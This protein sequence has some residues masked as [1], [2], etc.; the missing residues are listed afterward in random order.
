MGARG[1]SP[2]GLAI[3]ETD[4]LEASQ[5]EITGFPLPTVRVGDSPSTDDGYDSLGSGLGIFR[6]K[7]NAIGGELVFRKLCG[8]SAELLRGGAL[9]TG[10]RLDQENHHATGMIHVS[11]KGP[12]PRVPIEQ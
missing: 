3:S 2:G 8:V 12:L 4:R 5:K 6:E 9:P 10:V 1:D 7:H 11:V